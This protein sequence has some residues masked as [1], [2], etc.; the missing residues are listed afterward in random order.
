MA[1]PR[2]I[3]PYQSLYH[4]RHHRYIGQHD[5]LPI[6]MY[7]SVRF[8]QFKSSNRESRRVFFNALAQDRTRTSAAGPGEAHPKQHACPCCC[9]TVRITARQ[10]SAWKAAHDVSVIITYHCLYRRQLGRV[11]GRVRLLPRGVWLADPQRLLM[12]YRACVHAFAVWS[13]LIVRHT[14]LLLLFG[15]PTVRKQDH[16]HPRCLHASSEQNDRVPTLV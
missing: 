13:P 10:L 6:I 1:L 3:V 16:A 8:T 2:G 5:I 7:A 11:L 12:G 15:C 4:F 14:D 9:A